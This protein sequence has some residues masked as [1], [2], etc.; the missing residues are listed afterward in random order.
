M[1][2]I[3]P[4][5]A[6]MAAAALVLA[7]GGI[8][9]WQRP[10]S[11]PSPEPSTPEAV[12]AEP[13]NRVRRFSDGVRIDPSEQPKRW[14]AVMIENSAEAWPLSG[15]SEAR[16]VFEAPVEGS[17]PRFMALYDDTQETEKIGPVRS[18]RPYYLDWALGLDAMYAH[19]GGSPDALSKINR[20]AVA[21]LNQFFW[22]SFFWRSR[23]RY[24]PH[25]VYTSVDLLTEGFVK[26]GYQD[27]EVLPAL[28]WAYDDETLAGGE[29]AMRVRVPFSSL[30]RNY[31]AIWQYEAAEQGYARFQ[32]T[33]RQT[34]QNKTAV[35][36]ANV[37]VLQMAVS[38]IDDVGRR[39]VDTIGQGNGV[40]FRD[41]RR[42]P[43]TWKKSAREVPLEL[44]T[45]DGNPAALRAG[46]TWIEVVPLSTAI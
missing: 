21:S 36:A 45:A 1:K 39:E 46:V 13:D 30:S 23:D 10:A 41:G 9:Y 28:G 22:D 43:L 31:D 14:Y 16:L 37:V 3:S 38:V 35:Y 33:D 27:G 11:T 8:F 12:A 7:A 44:F 25:N 42:F 34:D 20:L 18:A 32:N 40:L 2:K 26:R 29:E 15:L 6:L 4:Q 17:I 5:Y 24:A 19:V